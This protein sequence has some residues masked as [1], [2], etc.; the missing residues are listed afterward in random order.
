MH[1]DDKRTLF[2]LREDIERKWL[3]VKKSDFDDEDLLGELFSS[4]ADY[5]DCKNSAQAD[6]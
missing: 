1:C 3:K 6:Q 2:A 5:I 4:I